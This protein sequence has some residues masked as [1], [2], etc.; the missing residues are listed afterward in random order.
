MNDVRESQSDAKSEIDLAKL[1]DTLAEAGQTLAV[2][3]SLTGGLLASTIVG[4]PG[5]SRV[6]LGG[7]VTYATESKAVVLGVN[8]ALLAVEGPVH[9][10]V[11]AQ[12]ATEVAARFGA[13]IGLACTGVAGPDEQDG[14]SVG[15]VYIA[16]ATDDRETGSVEVRELHCKG[17]RNQIRRQV[18]DQTL[19]LLGMV[20]EDLNGATGYA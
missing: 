2:A 16:V 3:E 18:V 17:N 4:I 15:L 11:A 19:N 9:P 10:E 12:M 6:F 1:L 13:T 5:A 7:I 8:S 20:W 14:K